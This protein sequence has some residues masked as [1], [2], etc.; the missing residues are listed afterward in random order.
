MK[1]LTFL[2]NKNFHLP[3]MGD[4]CHGPEKPENRR[5]VIGS[6]TST[7]L[8]RKMPCRLARRNE[9]LHLGSRIVR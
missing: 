7:Q 3:L 8:M 2:A 1:I 9:A 5:P 4:L 6:E